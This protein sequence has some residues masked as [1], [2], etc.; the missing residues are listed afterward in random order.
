MFNKKNKWTIFSIFIIVFLAIC[1][2]SNV[3]AATYTITTANSTESINEFFNPDRD[4]AAPSSYIL[5]DGDTVIFTA[6]KYNN[7]KMGIPNRITIKSSGKVEFTG[8]TQI[9]GWSPGDGIYNI[10]FIGLTINGNLN[11]G[12]GNTL[13]GCTINGN[14]NL[15]SNDAVSGTTISDS[16]I[17]G[18]LFIRSNN[19]NIDNNKLK[20]TYV[21]GDSN[22]ITNNVVANNF[23]MTV[24]GKKNTLKNNKQSYNDLHFESYKQNSKGLK[25]VVKNIGTKKTVACY[26]GVYKNN[27]KLVGKVKVSALKKGQSKTI[28]ISKKLMDKIKTKQGK[29]TRYLGRIKLDHNNKLKDADLNNNGLRANGSKNSYGIKK[30]N[31]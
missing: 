31:A 30:M 3:N 29:N 17:N 16:T 14:V 20:Y 25:V 19:N 8:N 15:E 12:S 21:S 26:I 10:E 6:G 24:V 7:L 5:N 1:M 28:I 27:G 13:S 22:K 4:G 23:K 2:L 11:L 18:N 9:S